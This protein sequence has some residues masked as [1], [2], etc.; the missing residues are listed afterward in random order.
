[1][2]K[3][4]VADL[5]ALGLLSGC[6]ATS[7]PSSKPTGSILQVRRVLDTEGTCV[8]RLHPNSWSTIS[9]ASK[10]LSAQACRCRRH[11]GQGLARS[12]LPGCLEVS[13]SGRIASLGL[14][15]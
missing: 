12:S 7:A 1:M 10:A 13:C 9:L 14:G 3:G 2:V 8:R 15:S 5:L 11:R 6:E 4:V